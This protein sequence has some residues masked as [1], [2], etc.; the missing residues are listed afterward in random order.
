MAVIGATD[1]FAVAVGESRDL[2]VIG[3]AGRDLVRLDAGDAITGLDQG[4]LAGI[5]AGD[6]D[7]PVGAVAGAKRPATRAGLL[8]FGDLVNW[9]RN[10]VIP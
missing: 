9:H 1:D 6:A 4:D 8:Q 10:P 2:A 5:V 3:I 7:D